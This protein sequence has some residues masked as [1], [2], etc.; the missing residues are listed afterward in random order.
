MQGDKY[1]IDMCS[2]PIFSKIIHN[3]NSH[4]KRLLPINNTK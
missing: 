3:C 2:G 4:V 1:S